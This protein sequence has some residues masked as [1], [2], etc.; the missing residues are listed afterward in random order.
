MLM[1]AKLDHLKYALIKIYS[2]VVSSPAAEH[3]LQT[4]FLDNLCDMF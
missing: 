2:S 3:R 1:T 4:M